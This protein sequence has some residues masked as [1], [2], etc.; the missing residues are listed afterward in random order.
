MDPLNE[1]ENKNY[2][3]KQRELFQITNQEE[4]C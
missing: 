2:L 4:S 3:E 1:F